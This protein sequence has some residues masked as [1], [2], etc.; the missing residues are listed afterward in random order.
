MGSPYVNDMQAI[1]AAL[2]PAGDEQQALPDEEGATQYVYRTQQGGWL[3]SPTPLEGDEDD[4]PPPGRQSAPP[5][6][7]PPP[8][9][10]PSHVIFALLLLAFLLLDSL[11]TTLTSLMTPTATITILPQVNTITLK[12]STALGKLLSPITLSQSLTVPATGKGHQDARAASGTLT[13]YNGQFQS[14]FIAADTVLTAPDGIQV[15][16]DSS[17][18]MPAGNPP[19]Y[20]QVTIAAHASSP[21]ASGNIA[22]YAISQPCC[23]A[24]VLVKNLA[25]FTGGQDERNFQV[26]TQ[27]DISMAA[28]TLKANVS[29]S[30]SAALEGQRMPGQALQPTPCTPTITTN[31]RPGDEATNVTVSVSQTCSAVFYNSQELTTQA[32]ARLTSQA[33]HTLAAGYSRYGTLRLTVTQARATQHTVI[34]SYIAQ[35]T[36]VY[37]INQTRIQALVSGKPR[38]EAL[39]LLSHMAGIKKVTISGISD[40]QELP[41]DLTRIHVLTVV[42]AQ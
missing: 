5:L 31:H 24:S 2:E 34:L 36:Y 27:E 35:A 13:F 41:T 7:T 15:L 20:G 32:I 23:A 3:I 9:H 26:V 28:T 38:L 19:A 40:N 14:V 37:Q 4:E 39:Q 21:G 42:F 10:V 30:T 17:A 6:Q 1:L 33:R 22:A 12:S 29:A 8:R 25:P 11:D 16:T 18:T